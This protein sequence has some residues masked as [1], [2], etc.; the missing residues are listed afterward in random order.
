[1][2]T[3]RRS[4]LGQSP[5]V[6]E[7][8]SD[9]KV[10]TRAYTDPKVFD[11]EMRNIFEKTWVYVAHESEIQHP[12]DYRTAAVGRMPVIVSRGE[13]HQVHVLLN[14]CRHRGS[15]VCHEEQG[16]SQY[17]RCPYHSWVYKNDGTLVGVADRKGYAD[18]W[19]SEIKGLLKAP[20]VATHK[21]MIF[22]SFSEEG[23]SLEE[24]LGPL[25]TYIDYWFGHSPNGRVQLTRP[26]R[27]FYP[28]NWK[29]QAENSTDGYHPRY[30]HESAFKTMDQFGTRGNSVQLVGCTR[31]FEGG[32]GILEATRND[33]PAEVEAEFTE[34]YDLLI[35]SYGPELAEQTYRRRHIAIFPNVHLMEFK[36]RVIQPVSVDKTI[37]YEFPVELDGVPVSINQAIF[38][39]ISKEI[40]VSS[41]SLISGFVNADDTE[42]FSRVQSGLKASRME[43]MYLARGLHREVR[44][45]S[46]EI[47]GDRTDE[48]PQRAIYRAWGRLMGANGSEA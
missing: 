1:M 34:L 20:R 39:R 42:I 27:G 36:V 16:N 30:V 11:D 5:L 48:V 15:T 14:V 25:T 12:G 28:A 41:G 17:F 22:A 4:Q 13:D 2:L 35:K 38:R 23:E 47:V 33:I 45:P 37:V 7:S 24:H 6:V 44:Q 43:W 19:G 8:A 46:G 40:S 26:Y 18:D 21:G 10:N 3:E 29:F 31:G 9:F 32:H